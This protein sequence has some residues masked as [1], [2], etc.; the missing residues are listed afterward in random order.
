[1]AAR[2]LKNFLQHG[3]I[4]NSINLPDCDSGSALKPRITVII[5][6][7]PNV[8]GPV[9]TA[10]ADANINIS[11]MLN[12]SKGDYSYNII[13]LDSPCPAATLEKIARL[14]GVVRARRIN[15]KNG[16]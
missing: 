3:N 9:T 16:K 15:G 1:M 6:N 11:N 12:K 14:K 8:V 10:L 5:Q 7:V 2:Q 13:D 4:K